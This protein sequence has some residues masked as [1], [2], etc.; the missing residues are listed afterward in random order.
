MSKK[1]RF[2]RPSDKQHGKRSETLLKYARQHLYHIYWS[3]WRKFSW[4]KSV[5][6]ICKILE[7]FFNI[8]I[9]DDKYSFLNRDH[10]TPLIQMHLSNKITFCQFSSLFLTSRSHFEHFEKKNM[11]LMAYIFP[12]L[13]TAKDVVREMSKKSRF[14]RTFNNQ[15]GKQSQTLL[16]FARQHLHNIY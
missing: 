1:S 15:N 11:I 13:R 5:L 6:V 8:L 16:R 2:T 4:K 14:K 3:L 12:K 7:P 9:A 10:L